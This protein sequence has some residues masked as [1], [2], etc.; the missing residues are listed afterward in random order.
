[1]VHIPS[2]DSL[3]DTSEKDVSPY[4]EPHYENQDEPQSESHED[5][6]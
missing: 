1:V 6:D 4:Y 2:E 3:S 5:R